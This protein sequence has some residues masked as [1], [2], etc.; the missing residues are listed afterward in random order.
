MRNLALLSI[1]L[2]NGCASA[3]VTGVCLN[4]Q[5]TEM[6]APYIGGKINANGVM[7]HVGC[8]GINKCA[9][10]TVDQLTAIMVPF[11]N[12]QAGK[13]NVTGP[14]TVQFIPAK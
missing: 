3:G 7:C 11:S 12:N 13:I 8:D 5:G 10:P 2:L 14:G 4:I 1:L 9:Q 6:S